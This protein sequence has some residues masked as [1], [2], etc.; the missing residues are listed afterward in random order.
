MSHRM[1]LNETSYFGAGA[2]TEL[3][4]EVKR[5]GYKK[6]LVVT[7]AVLVKAGTVAKVTSLMDAAGLAYELFDKVMPNPTIGVVKEGVVNGVARE[8]DGERQIAAG[9]AFRQA[10]EVRP[11]G[12][13]L[14]GK[15]NS[16][17][18]PNNVP[19]F[20]SYGKQQSWYLFVA[21]PT[22]L[23]GL[24]TLSA[25][26]ALAGLAGGSLFALTTDLLGYASCGYVPR[27]YKNLFAFNLATRPVLFAG[28]MIARH[29]INT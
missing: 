18:N 22:I 23:G 24:S 15:I 8:D 19:D 2:R 26:G 11:D 6:A 3:V 12:R 13:L 1:I 25:S 28:A 16:A 29:L 4:G 7:D 21:A 10:Q 14:A 5:R 20:W 9:N 27:D 17:L